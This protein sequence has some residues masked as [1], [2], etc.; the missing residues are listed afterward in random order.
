[1][2]I[3]RVS[4]KRARISAD[5]TT[6]SYQ[7]RDE[8]EIGSQSQVEQ[9]FFYLIRMWFKLKLSDPPILQGL[10]VQAGQKLG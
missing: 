5:P 2:W 9:N 1:M 4:G 6:K 10:P 8:G 7:I 3:K